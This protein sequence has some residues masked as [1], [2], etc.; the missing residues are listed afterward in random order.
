MTALSG[1]DLDRALDEAEALLVAL[2]Q[3]DTTNPPG[4]E[5]PAAEIVADALRADGLEPQIVQSAPTRANLVCRLEGDGTSAPLLLSGH[6]DVVGADPARWRQPPFSGARADGCIWGRGALDMKGFVAQATMVMRL[7]AREG[8]RPKRDVIFAAVADE[9]AGCDQGSRFLVDHHAELVR[10]EYAL[11]EIGGFTL[12][13]LGRRFYPIQFA[14][15]GIVWMRGR[16]FGAPGHGSMPDPASAVVQLAQAVVKMGE[17]PLP[18]H[19]TPALSSF[20]EAMARELPPPA[21]LAL[22]LVLQP[23]LSSVLLPRLFKDPGQ[24]RAFAALLS[25]TATP[26]ILRAGEKTNVIPG[27]ATCEIDGRTLPG[28][29]A[30]DLVRELREIVGPEIVLEV[31]KSVPATQT[32]ID[33]PMFQMLGEAVRRH[34]PVGI[35]IPYLIPGFTDA[36][37]W[38]R[39]GTHCYGFSPLKLEEDSGVVFAK[40][41]HGDDERV[42][43]A[44]FRWGVEVLYDL[45]RTAT[46]L[47]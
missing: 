30:E 38:S 45:V 19:V 5:R 47:T 4:N 20:V 42:P 15:K 41:F 35:P 28:Q 44:G 17:E 10:A 31:A 25:N 3:V 39:L 23:R 32:T 43:I 29:T 33:T 34:D 7:L 14:E 1:T 37:S 6:L 24:R 46:G 12:H 11:G 27:E 9:E 22:T 18:V 2:L 40:L 26:T 16:A 36:A 8:A 13:L 21:R